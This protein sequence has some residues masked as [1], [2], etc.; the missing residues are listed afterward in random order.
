MTVP[1]LGVSIT[2]LPKPE[3]LEVET[4][5]PSGGVTVRFP[6]KAEPETVK[7]AVEEGVP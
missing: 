5:N 1:L 2:V 4:T 7:L 6:V 3:L